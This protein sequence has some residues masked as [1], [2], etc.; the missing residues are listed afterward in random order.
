MAEQVRVQV[1]QAAGDWLHAPACR[2]H[3]NSAP[4]IGKW[5]DRCDDGRQQQQLLQPDLVA[6]GNVALV[7][8]VALLFK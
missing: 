5:F 2:H 8:A 6:P 7:L 1:G 4:A 3:H